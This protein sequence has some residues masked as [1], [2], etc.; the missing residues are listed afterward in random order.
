MRIIWR[1]C[2][3]RGSLPSFVSSALVLTLVIPLV[4]P[5]GPR[6]SS[7]SR[8]TFGPRWRRPPAF[9]VRQVPGCPASLH[10]LVAEA[11]RGYKSDSEDPKLPRAVWCAR[12]LGRLRSTAVQIQPY[13]RRRRRACTWTNNFCVDGASN[14]RR[15]VTLAPHL[16]A[17]LS[18]AEN[19]SGLVVCRCAKDPCRWPRWHYRRCSRYKISPWPSL[20]KTTGVYATQFESST[21]A[22]PG[23]TYKVLVTKQPIHKI[24][25]QCT[26]R[27][28]SI[29]TNIKYWRRI[30]FKTPERDLESIW[31]AWIFCG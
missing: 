30:C 10:R 16:S 4:L 11:Q 5:L 19:A 28:I 20:L 7:I 23:G 8:S 24:W 18:S 26:Q 2:V 27:Y 3:G 29:S 17:V 25:G 21:A 1:S 31:R 22:M 6:V 9:P 13:W 14:Y 12:Q 15:E